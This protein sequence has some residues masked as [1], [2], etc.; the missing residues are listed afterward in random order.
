MDEKQL[1]ITE[2]QHFN[3]EIHGTYDAPLFKAKDIGDLLGMKNIRKVLQNF[4]DKQRCDVTL[5]DAIGREQNTTFLTEQG[6]Y[7][8]LMRSRKKIAEEK[9]ILTT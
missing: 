5:S 7:K 2:F 8:L 9:N 6:L 1:L 4:N 3:I